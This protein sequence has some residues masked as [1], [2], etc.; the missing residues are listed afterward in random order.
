MYALSYQCTRKLRANNA[1]IIARYITR[2]KLVYHIYK[3]TCIQTTILHSSWQL[4]DN[5]RHPEDG[6]HTSGD[7][8]HEW[9]VH[10]RFSKADEIVVQL[11][12]RILH[13]ADFPVVAEAE[14]VVWIE[15]RVV[16]RRS[17]GRHRRQ[18]RIRSRRR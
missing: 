16:N 8:L 1:E 15:P 14:G 17:R 4:P 7:V 5:F 9:L 2:Q 12:E 6:V 18:G 3:G 11:V 13:D 10:Q